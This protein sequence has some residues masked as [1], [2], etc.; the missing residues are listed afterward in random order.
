M[1]VRTCLTASPVHKTEREGGGAHL[2]HLAAVLEVQAT[3]FH[4]PTNSKSNAGSS[5]TRPAG[6]LEARFMLLTELVPVQIR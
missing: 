2:V 3:C 1:K 6:D 4:R 5:H